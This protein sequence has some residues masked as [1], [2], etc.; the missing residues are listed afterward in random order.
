MSVFGCGW[1]A[2]ACACML[3]SAWAQS[4]SFTLLAAPGSDSSPFN[5]VATGINDSGVVVGIDNSAFGA[6]VWLG[7]GTNPTT[8]P[9]PDVDNFGY[10]WAINASGEI[11]GQSAVSLQALVWK[12]NGSSYAYTSLG[13]VNAYGNAIGASGNVAGVNNGVATLWTWNGASYTPHFLAGGVASGINSSGMVVGYSAANRAFVA[14]WDGS[15]FSALT[16]LP[17]ISGTFGF[18][19]GIND[20][21]QIVGYSEGDGGSK[22]AT[23]WNL[24]G[25]TYVA[26]NLGTLGGP[27]SIASAINASGQIVGSSTISSNPAVG[28][29]AF[30]YQNG[31]MYDLNDIV[32]G[33]TGWTLFSAQGINSIGQIVGTASDTSGDVLPFLLNPTGGGPTPTPTPTSGPTPSPTPTPSTTLTPSPSPTPSATPTPTATRVP[34]PTPRPSPTPR[35]TPSATPTPTPTRAP[36][37]TPRPS[38]SPRPS[39]TP[40]LTPT[41]TRVPTPT[42]RPSP[43]P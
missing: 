21:G 9:S 20:S 37:P 5:T 36:T 18:A 29:H 27:N 7:P 6:E 41:P 1:A 38:P 16:T 23:L 34:T 19:F 40:S 30:L 43:T 3:P 15:A 2:L 13:G 8:L 42:P 25:S 39:P 26:T 35:P 14:T 10:A 28:Q 32:T 31:T 12:W 11:A 17:A 22:P 24:V 33:A 4:Y